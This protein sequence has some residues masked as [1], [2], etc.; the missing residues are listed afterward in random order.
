MEAE[1][2]DRRELVVRGAAAAAALG[3]AACGSSSSTVT[4]NAIRRRRA[5]GK[6]SSS[7]GNLADSV[8]GRVLT[9]GARGYAAA[10][11]VYNERYDGARPLAILRARDDADVQAA[12]RWAARHDVR[13]LP[14]SG[15]HSYAGYSTGN[16]A[17]VVD[18]SQLRAVRLDR[19]TGIADIGPGAQ[20]VDVYLGLARHG[21]TI[22]AGTCP[23]VGAGGHFLGGGFGLASR[24]FGLACDNLLEAEVVTADG[25]RVVASARSHADLLWACRGGGGGNFGVVTRLRMRTHRVSHAAHFHLSWAWPEASE[26]IDAWQHHA[27]GASRD[28]TSVLHLSAGT[29]PLVAVNGQFFGSERALR[30]ALGPLLDVP[31]ASLSSGTLG[32]SDLMLLW[33][34]CESIGADA[35]H[36]QGTHKGGTLPRARFVAKSQY[37]S[38]PLGSDG[39]RALIAA[40]ERTPPAGGSA[41]MLLDSYGGAVNQPGSHDT[42]FVHRDELFSIQYLA[43]FPP[44]GTHEAKRWAERAWRDLRPHAT[45]QA[46]QNYIDP[47]LGGWAEAYYGSNLARLREV[48]RAYDPDFRFR[49]AQAIEPA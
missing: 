40:A 6:T 38:H 23:S 39:R 32:Y 11:R 21:A 29:S 43:Y 13:V 28:L 1:R 25:R 34:N 41:S 33:A 26:A 22:P 24:R 10:T 4:L 36:T 7:L 19:S 46:Y 49:F 35:C 42:A 5:A 48:K 18:V 3:L 8:R 20:L 30:R 12:V 47:D 27:R 16:D 37:V 17:L 31:G 2:L 9:P 15:G 45:K 44:G 14:R